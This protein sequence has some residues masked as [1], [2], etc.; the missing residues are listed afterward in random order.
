VRY[1]LFGWR[2]AVLD[3]PKA[4]RGRQ[5]R[6]CPPDRFFCALLAFEW[7]GLRIF[8]FESRV[9]KL[10]ATLSSPLT[11]SYLGHS[12]PCSAAILLADTYRHRGLAFRFTRFSRAEVFLFKQDF[13][14]VCPSANCTE[15]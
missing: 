11:S 10:L 5:G 7:S 8:R 2:P 9:R 4:L 14:A 13:S 6:G 3:F 1:S 15:E 12:W